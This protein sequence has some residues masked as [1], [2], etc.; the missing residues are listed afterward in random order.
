MGLLLDRGASV[1][2]RACTRYHVDSPERQGPELYET[3][4]SLAITNAGLVLMWRLID[5]GAPLQVPL[6][7]PGDSTGRG[8][9]L[10]HIAA[11]YA[12]VK[13]IEILLDIILEGRDMATMRDGEGHLPLHW[14]AGCSRHDVFE[15]PAY[16]KETT[17]SRVTATLNMLLS[18]SPS[19]NDPDSL[20]DTPLHYAAHRLPRRLDNTIRLL[21]AQGADP[22]LAN[23]AGTRGPVVP[24]A[25]LCQLLERRVV[26]D[27]TGARCAG[28]GQRRRCEPARSAE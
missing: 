16:G 14:A 12:N 8:A 2:D 23:H 1:Q 27:Q 3:V 4:L 10:M 5:L 21:L 19:F 26:G 18:H 6:R 13:V 22:T 9:T 17:A 24:G 15:G 11:T 28:G 25:P 20:G 7:F